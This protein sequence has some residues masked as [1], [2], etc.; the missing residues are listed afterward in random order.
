M[1]IRTSL[2]VSLTPEYLSGVLAWLE[3]GGVY[4]VANRRGGGEYG[5]DWHRAGMRDRKPQVFADFEIHRLADG[6]EVAT[7]PLATEAGR[8]GPMVQLR[9][10]EI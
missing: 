5:E 10:H 9:N 8:R 2:N 7:S 4:A 3:A 6:T 1:P